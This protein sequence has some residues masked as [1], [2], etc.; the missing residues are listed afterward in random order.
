MN[1][2]FLY[3][4][5]LDRVAE[6]SDE[7]EEGEFSSGEENDD[8]IDLGIGGYTERQKNNLRKYS[9][10]LNNLKILKI[11]KI[12]QLLLKDLIKWTVTVN[13]K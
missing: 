11:F 1:E 5:Y 4:L 13:L 2:Y 3:F 8:A 6:Y 9:K 10:I 12:V 7:D